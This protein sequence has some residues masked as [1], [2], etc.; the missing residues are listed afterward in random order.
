MIVFE[1][2]L[3]NRNDGGHAIIKYCPRRRKAWIMIPRD[4][5]VAVTGAHFRRIRVGSYGWVSPDERTSTTSW[6]RHSSHGQFMEDIRRARR[7][8]LIESMQWSP[9][10][11]CLRVI[12]RTP[13]SLAGEIVIRAFFLY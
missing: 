3:S 12:F 11:R 1:P 10:G 5:R 2:F 4:E 9:I 6:T 13:V 7:H 8:G